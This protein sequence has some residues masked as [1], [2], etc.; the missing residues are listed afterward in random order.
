M[1]QEIQKVLPASVTPDE[2][3]L[4]AVR[5]KLSVDERRNEFYALSEQARRAMAER[6]LTESEILAEFES[7]RQSLGALPRR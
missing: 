1:P 5:E 3:V 4:A 6:G 2:F 7:S